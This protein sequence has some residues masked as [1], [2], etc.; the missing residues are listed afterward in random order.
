M[1]ASL[2]LPDIVSGITAATGLH[3]LWQT[4]EQRDAERRKEQQ[5]QEHEEDEKERHPQHAAAKEADLGD[6]INFVR[7]SP[8]KLPH[9]QS[10]DNLPK[11][12]EPH[13]MNLVEDKDWE[14]EEPR[15]LKDSPLPFLDRDQLLHTSQRENTFDQIR[16]HSS[17]SQTTTTKFDR[18]VARRQQTMPGRVRSNITSF[19]P[20][21]PEANKSRNTARSRW[22]AAAHGL[23]FRRKKRRDAI[24]STKGTALV[25]TLAAGAPAANI[26]ASHMVPDERGHRRIPII[27]ELL[28]VCISCINLK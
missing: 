16:P 23:R 13:E 15:P 6:E 2:E 26:F 17:R 7:P 1:S 8:A 24:A 25:S 10:L 18:P 3:K 28:K 11:A 12:S 4:E 22:Q 21:A 14:D 5:E 20:E 19:E 27:V 9:S